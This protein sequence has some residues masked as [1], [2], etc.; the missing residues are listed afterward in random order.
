MKWDIYISKFEQKLKILIPKFKYMKNMFETKVLRTL[1]FTL[2]ESP[3]RH[4]I[5][6][7]GGAYNNQIK[8]LEIL[9]KWILNIM[10]PSHIIFHLPN[11]LDINIE[12]SGFETKTKYYG[13][14]KPYT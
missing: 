14:C 9:Q 11:L 3:L 2:V 10:Y 12:Y 4:G 6:V 13:L 5:I 7:W 1:Y 8:P